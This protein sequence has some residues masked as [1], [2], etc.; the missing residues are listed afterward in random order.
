MH[1]IVPVKDLAAAKQRLSPAL[2]AEA[3]RAL[4]RAMLEDVAFALSRARAPRAVFFVTRDPEAAALASSLAFRLVWDEENAGHTQAVR[5]GIAA[6]LRAGAE[7]VLVVPADVPLVTADDIDAIAAARLETG[8]VFVPSRDKRGTNAVLLA[9]PDIM[10]LRFGSDSFYPHLEAAAARNIPFSV[11]ELPRLALDIDT[12]D[13]LALFAA[14]DADTRAHRA[15]RE[16][17]K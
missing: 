2:G 11:L 1:A 10:P 9:P 5:L 14:S 17:V 15:L 16:L 12:P 8:A 13:D 7:A 3:R 4:A 6:C